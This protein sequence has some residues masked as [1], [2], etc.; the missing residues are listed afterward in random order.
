MYICLDCGEIFE[1]P[2]YYTEKHGLD[3][4]PYE[5]YR[6][7]PVCGGGYEGAKICDICKSYITDEYIVT[8]NND[9]ICENCYIKHT[10]GDD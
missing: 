2:K 10:I 8:S 7:C 3:T 9:I 6:G 4:P 1:E 5:E